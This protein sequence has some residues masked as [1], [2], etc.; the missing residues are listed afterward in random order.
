M[1]NEVNFACHVQVVGDIV[2]NEPEAWFTK[3]LIEVVGPTCDQIVDH[4]DP[5]THA[6]Q[7]IT[8]VRTQE[9]ASPPHPLLPPRPPPPGL[10]SPLS[11]RAPPGG[12]PT[13]GGGAPPKEPCWGEL[14]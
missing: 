5:G 1:K 8:Q 6:C 12:P 14:M 2:V 13:P 10:P 7:S 4:R 9:P 11:P 3:Q